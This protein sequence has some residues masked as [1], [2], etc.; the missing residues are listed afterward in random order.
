MHP[1][2]HVG[3]TE[4]VRGHRHSTPSLPPSLYGAEGRRPAQGGGTCNRNRAVPRPAPVIAALVFAATSVAS[5]RAQSEHHVLFPAGYQ[6]ATPKNEVTFSAGSSS[7]TYNVQGARDTDADLMPITDLLLDAAFL[8][9]NTKVRIT[10]QLVTPAAFAAVYGAAEAVGG[11]VTVNGRIFEG[12][13]SQ[14]SFLLRVR[15]DA[16]ARFAGAQPINSQ[17]WGTPRI[18]IYEGATADPALAFA[19]SAHG[20]GTRTWGTGDPTTAYRCL[21]GGDAVTFSAWPSAAG[22]DSTLFRVTPTSTSAS[23]GNGRLNLTAAPD[24]EIPTDS[25]G[26]NVYQV[27]VRSGHALNSLVGEGVRTGCD[28]SALELTIVVKDAGPP[29]PVRS[30]TGSL[31][32]GTGTLSVNWAP[33]AG[34]LDGSDS[35]VVVP[36][37]AARMSGS[38][39]AGTAVAGYDY[40]HRRQ[41]SST[42]T[43]GTTTAT[44]FEISGVGVGDAHTVRV[45]ARNAEGT[46]A[47]VTIDVE[48]PGEPRVELPPDEPLP[49]EPSTGRPRVSASCDPC[50]VAPGGEVQLTAT[51]SDPDGDPLTYAWSAAEGSFDGATDAA[52][53]RWTAPAAA[54]R[55]ELRVRVSDGRGASA[56]AT[57]T[58]EVANEPPAFE[59]SE[60]AFELR[61]NVDGTR[62]P[63]DL[64]RVTARD[65]DGDELTYELA[66]GDRSRFEVGARDGALRYMG[67]GED[68]ESEAT[69]YELAVR[70]RDP[71]GARAEVGV[72]VTITNVNEPPEAKDD[73]AATDEDEA[74]TVDVLANDSDPDGDRLRVESSSA[75]AHGTTAVTKGAVRY[76]PALNHYGVDRFTYVVS[77]GNGETAEAVVEVTVRPVNDAPVAVG[78][79]PDQALDEGGGEATVELTPFFEDVDGD[80]LAY[81]ASSTDLSVAV[82]AI[83][84]AVL[85]L[86]PV[87]YGS[88]AVTVT[89][90]DEGGLTAT[91]TFAVGVSDRLVRGVVSETLAGM[92][93]SHVAS[94]RMTLGRRVTA[95]PAEPPRLALLGRAVPLDKAAARTAAKQMLMSWLSSWTT[96]PGGPAG[97]PGLGAGSAYGAGMPAAGGPATAGMP[98]VGGLAGVAGWGSLSGVSG[99]SG[100][101]GASGGLGGVGRLG[102]FG[103]FGGLHNGA[104]PLRGSEFLW[105]LGAG[106]AGDETSGPGRRWRVW[107]QGDVQMFQGAPSAVT[108]YDGEL[109]TAYAGVDTWVTER[110]RAGAAVARSR[111]HGNWRAGGSQGALATTLTAVHPYV[112]WSDA[113]TSVWATAGG[114][115][116]AVENVRRSRR[117]GASGLG[118]RL[119]LV[120]LRRRLGAADGGVQFGVRADGAWAALRTVAGEESIDDQA[121]AVNQVRVGA[122][123]SRPVRLGAVALAPFGEAHVR[124]DGGAGQWGQGLEVV[125]GLRAAAGEVRVDAQGRMLAVHSAAGYRER[126]VGVTLSVGNQDREGLSLSVSPRWGDSAMGGGTLWQEQVYHR[127]LPEV[128]RDEWALDARSE[129]GIRRPSGRLLTW[130]GSWSRSPFGRRFLVGG[131]VGVLD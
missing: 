54:G 24:Y 124:R 100:V 13:T 2:V 10:P 126:G 112:Q 65:P 77:D 56:S 1:L 106:E 22:E 3:S 59:S 34:F 76:T 117:R 63:V 60:Y 67:P 8:D 98:A 130:F 81:R 21:V 93:R 62:R 97:G 85:T 79:I 102:G 105:S 30:L 37:D 73:E 5:L 12:N 125:A 39:A 33:P 44:S 52:T 119:G 32:R 4:R 89:A 84:G 120:E 87:E 17:R 28:G 50:R 116:G 118:L 75:P 113:T 114:G 42:W 122:E 128:E 16:S 109:Q 94:V 25:G 96:P 71:H 80:A 99:V 74:V 68:F 61:E 58:V 90:E 7:S 131:S 92:A 107:G 110:W 72:A 108:G 9:S 66:S 23:S 40:E 41:G 103:G 82:M 45:R 104:D 69:R 14:L 121:A 55:V 19:W 83:S 38:G 15:Y 35:S 78:V 36:F 46:G 18:E 43:Q 53:A 26:D 64:G 101:S 47:F 91:Q 48:Q 115:W 6:P 95:N 57:V 20:A 111:G 29:A 27:R 70:A 88:A 11:D 86:T 123:V 127:Y 129:Y 51:A 31:D 49:E